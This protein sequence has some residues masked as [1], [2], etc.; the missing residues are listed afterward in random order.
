[1]VGL[2]GKG[3]DGKEGKAN[4]IEIS[5]GEKKSRYRRNC[6]DRLS[7]FLTSFSMKA[8]GF[9]IVDPSPL[10]KRKVILDLWRVGD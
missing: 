3:V 9:I 10:H 6:K 4:G 8:A 5:M 2:L 1:M 7:G